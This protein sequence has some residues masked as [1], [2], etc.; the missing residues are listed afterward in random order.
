MAALIRIRRD[1]SNN[2]ASN[3][4]QLAQGELGLDTDTGVIKVGN[5][6]NVWSDLHSIG[7]YNSNDRISKTVDTDTGS[8]I[9]DKFGKLYFDRGGTLVFAD[10][11]NLFAGT[12]NSNFKITL[13][14]HTGD[15]TEY[16]FGHD[17]KITLPAGGLIST[18]WDSSSSVGSIWATDTEAALDWTGNSTI[19]ARNNGV[20]IYTSSSVD[21]KFW[22]FTNSGVLTLPD[23]GQLGDLEGYTALFNTD[24]VALAA[25]L[26]N[27]VVVSPTDGTYIY[28]NAAQYIFDANSTV[29]LP[30]NIQLDSSSVILGSTSN[31]GEDMYIEAIDFSVEDHTVIMVTSHGFMDGD[32]I[33]IN[34]I[35]PGSTEELDD[36]YCYVLVIDPD[37][38][39]IYSD[40]ALTMPIWDAGYTTFVYSGQQ[41]L[42]GTVARIYDAGSV[43]ISTTMPEVNHDHGSINLNV[44]DNI[45]NFGPDGTVTFPMGGRIGATKGGTS[46]DGGPNGGTT[47]LSNYYANGNYAACVT[48][49][50]NGRLYIT[51]YNDGGDNPSRAWEFNNDGNLVLPANG[52][53]LNSDF[54][55]YG[56]TG[57]AGGGISIW[58]VGND[59]SNTSVSNDGFANLNDLWLR[60]G[61]SLFITTGINDGNYDSQWMFGGSLLQLP[62]FGAITSPNYGFSFNKDSGKTGVPELGTDVTFATESLDSDILDGQVYMGSGY[63]EFRSIYNNVD[64]TESGL[65]YAGVE[66]FNYAHIGDVN[67]AGMVSQTPNI[68]SMYALSL[69]EQGQI[70]IGF[71]QDGQTQ[72]SNDWSV[73]VGTLNTDYTVNGLFANTNVT[74]IG[75]GLSSWTFGTDGNLTLPAGGEIHSAAGVGNVQINSNDGANSY[76]WTFGTNGNITFPDSTIQSTAYQRTTGSWNVNVGSGT[77]SFTVLQNG[78]YTM[79]VRGSIPNGIIVWNA[80]A[81]VSNA[82]VPVIGQ[83]YAW[84]YTGGGTPIE[85]TAIPTQFVG[86]AGTIVSSNPSVGTTS[87]VFNFTINNTSGSAKTVYWGYVTQ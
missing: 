40:K 29:H 78:T 77:Y 22:N 27:A 62:N 3:D 61:D 56:G 45:W 53:I 23:G 37:N 25:G 51:T 60:A 33:Y 75:S 59:T 69:N 81:T 20:E 46:F 63:G 76:S 30:G 57:G 24:G 26:D 31:T 10:T 35:G 84:N 41:P 87:N 50:S 52:Y 13:D 82:N 1:T 36:T 5:G 4:P 42:N 15:V 28:A 21:E 73:V 11:G 39:E 85:I 49:Y 71:T 32:K 72:T 8:L 58:R 6:S 79:W 34:N 80:T 16:N 67:F 65:V 55:V 70:T 54:T 47:S 83:Q 14:D 64:S 48:A 12:G 18:G 66:G 44:N 19:Y 7:V 17:G 68:D 38:F 43:N 74:V 86:T 9:V 2:W